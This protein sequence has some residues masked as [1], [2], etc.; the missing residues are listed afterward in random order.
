MKSFYTLAFASLILATLCGNKGQATE[1]QYSVHPPALS[2]PSGKPG[3]IRR[4]IMQFN[5]WTLICD[6]NRIQKKMVCNVTQSIQDK[7]D[8]VV[9][10]WS[11]AATNDG[12]PFFLLRTPAN[13][14]K[15]VPIQITFSG[16]KTPIK[17]AYIDCNE[18]VCLAQSAILPIM[19]EK[20]DKASTAQ[21]TYQRQ[22]GTKVRLD[23]PLKGLKDAVASIK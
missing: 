7:Q 19:W 8:S 5:F 6:E 13:S 14:D 10:S 15:K 18:N 17:I 3:E 16:L 9:F 20:I 2:V 12:K 1:E 21:I 4:S 23:A 22:N 11:L